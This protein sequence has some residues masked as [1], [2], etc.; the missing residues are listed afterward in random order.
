MCLLSFHYLEYPTD[1]MRGLFLIALLVAALAI[2]VY[3]SPPQVSL[4]LP[5]VQITQEDVKQ[6][7][8][9]KLHREQPASFLVSGHLDVSADITQE[10]TKYLFPDYFDKSISLGTTKSTVRL[11]GRVSYGIDL[12]KIEDVSITFEPDNVVVITLAELEV[13]AVEPD[14]ENMQIQTDVGWARLHAWSGKAVE[15]KALIV[16][17]NA[18]EAEAIG[19]LRT[20]PQPAI[21]TEAAL[22]RLL[23]PVLTSAGVSNPVIRFRTGSIRY[24]PQG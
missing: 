24:A 2:G 22:S 21:N 12:T 9:S 20:S 17:K 14:L 18:L 6:L 5:E 23:V 10:N 13:E 3:L 11:P 1:Q 15:R 8:I 7:I 4:P 19:H 16:A